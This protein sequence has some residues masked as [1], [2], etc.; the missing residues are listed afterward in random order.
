M[1]GNTGAALARLRGIEGRSLDGTGNNP[2][3]DSWGAIGQV[4]VRIAENSYEDGSGLMAR[5]RPLVWQPAGTQI[6]PFLQRPVFINNPSDE[7]P[8]GRA[9]PNAPDGR[10]P[11]T[12]DLRFVNQPTGDLPQARDISNAVFAQPKDASGE[13]LFIPNANG[14][15]DFGLFF[16][17]ALTHDMVETQVNVTAVSIP[18][19]TG[20]GWSG[21]QA[22][23]DGNPTAAILVRV[24]TVTGQP[25]RDGTGSVIPLTEAE[26]AALPQD[27]PAAWT[28]ILD[29]QV[30]SKGSPFALQRTPGIEDAAGVRQQAN[31]ETAFLDLG[32]VYGRIVVATL[33]AA[34]TDLNHAAVLDAALAG[35]GLTAVVTLDTSVLLRGR[36]AAGGPS[37]FLLTS[38]DVVD[39]LRDDQGLLPTY[40]EVNA[41]HGLFTDLAG[42][43]A[44]E[45]T[46]AMG[47]VFD[48]TLEAFFDLDRF[49]AGDQR[50]NQNAATV[51]QQTVWMRNHNWHAEQL[52]AQ[53][54]DWTAQEVFDLARALNEAEYQ[55]AIHDEYL[56]GLIG[57][58]GVA[59]MGGYAGYRPEVNPGIINE[60]TTVA[61]RF[62]HDQSSNFVEQLR[63]DGA[64]AERVALIE[65]F[66]RA[67]AATAVQSAAELDAWLRG[68]LA[69]AHQAIDG[70]VVDGNR[71]QLFGVTVSPVTGQPVQTDLTVFDIVR[72]RDH[73]VNGYMQ[74]REALG[75]DP[76]GSFDAW[77]ADNGV[78]AERLAALKELYGDDFTR[79]DAYVGVLLEAPWQDSQL[80]ITSTLL[81]AMQFAA[82]R[83]GDRLW[84][85]NRFAD[86]PE[87]LALIEAGS[88]ATVLKRSTGIE[89][90]YRDAFMAHERIGGTD[91]DDAVVGSAGRDLLIGFGGHDVLLGHGGRDDLHGDVGDDL[92]DGGAEA[93][94]LLGGA[95]ADTL[96]GGD[97]DD[98][99][100]G[101]EGANL[102]SGGAG[103]DRLGGDGGPQRGSRIDG[104][105]GTDT[106]LL[107]A[108]PGQHVVLN[109]AAGRVRGGDLHGSD[110]SAIE[111]VVLV[112]PG[113]AAILRGDAAANRLEGGDRSDWLAGRDGDDVLLGQ[114]GDDRLSGADGADLLDGGDGNDVLAGGAGDDLFRFALRADGHAGIDIV[115]DF[116]R[117]GDDRIIIDVADPGAAGLQVL[118]AGRLVVIRLD[119]GGEI[120]LPGAAGRFDLANPASE[121]E[122]I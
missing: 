78:S 56:P 79:L 96:R 52:A 7:I 61:F 11:L 58:A 59:L 94:L 118:V 115:R 87:I 35:D 122:L 101:G 49:A 76:Y 117:E 44:D 69:A 17:Q 113:A 82:T 20:I 34:A 39:G 5:A 104:G 66:T 28:A 15:N 25:L 95:G 4:F 9:G 45:I 8:Q 18:A 86:S 33:D 97:G 111:Q 38:D 70:F 84:W 22:D 19:A 2:A 98:T 40:G 24:D 105:E 42:T 106:L 114:A 119:T 16:G 60:W 47:R 72:G 54:P 65:S 30:L 31:T 14:L 83:D 37:A 121:I 46:Q 89:H 93:D 62:G 77:A 68:Q 64:V 81:V 32:N 112:S 103:D 102:L 74:L 1:S 85:E 75:L 116:D 10:I 110:V 92:L 23:A 29:H 63:E 120:L 51:T 71:N 48:P 90:I 12:D 53:F 88:M 36:D 67:G 107:T 109:L 41:F 26:I 100:L 27:N 3:D 50:V 80:G 43:T 91:G 73:G 55:K 6:D 21:G 13:D 108:A 57:A 99:L